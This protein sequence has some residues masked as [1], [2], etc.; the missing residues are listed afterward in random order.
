MAVVVVVEMDI[1]FEN[2]YEMPLVVGVADAAAVADE[3]VNY[4]VKVMVMVDEI[5]LKEH[6]IHEMIDVVIMDNL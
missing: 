2:D 6:V 4:E 5:R 3:Y 1:V